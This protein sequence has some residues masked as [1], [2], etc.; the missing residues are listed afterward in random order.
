M[1]V[2]CSVIL[3]LMAVFIIYRMF[4]KAKLLSHELKN[5]ELEKQVVNA[6]LNQT[7]EKIKE[8]RKT[9]DALKSTLEKNT[10]NDES[11]IKIM[12]LLDQ[13]YLDEQ[14]WMK[15]IYHYDILNDG[16]TEKVKTKYH[17]ITQND[18]QLL[19]LIQLGYANKEIASIRNI[20]ESGVK[21]SKS[22]LLLKMG[23]NDFLSAS[24]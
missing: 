6:K 1:I 10:K 8:K 22:R 16:F 24:I 12:A 15:L 4:S 13:Q 11:K 2:F 14:N 9:I 21:K 20:T 5:T 17:K 3:L 7:I 18:L 23:L 19:I